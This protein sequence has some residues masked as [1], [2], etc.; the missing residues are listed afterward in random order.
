[1]SALDATA[2]GVAASAMPDDTRLRLETERP[3][4]LFGHR[5]V[6]AVEAPAPDDDVETK[7]GGTANDLL[8][9]AAESQ[10]TEPLTAKAA[11]LR[12]GLLVPLPGAQL[13][14]VVRYSA[15]ERQHQ[16]ERQLGD[17]NGVLART[18]G[19][20]DAARGRRRHV[21]RVVARP[22]AHDEGQ[23]AGIERRRRDLRAADDEHVSA[24]RPHCLGQAVVFD[25]RCIDDFASGGS[26]TVETALFEAVGY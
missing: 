21:N 6:F 3:R 15:I 10:H 9:D 1:M 2:A 25:V 22:S 18:V 7:C 16:P 5:P 26:Q 14:D 4:L 19:D 17:G 11:R 12:E 20:V 23:P 13:R 8:R 24:A